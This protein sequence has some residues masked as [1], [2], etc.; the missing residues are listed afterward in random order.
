MLHPLHPGFANRKPPHL[1]KYIARSGIFGLI[2]GGIIFSGWPESSVWV[3]GLIPGIDLISNGV[4]WLSFGLRHSGLWHSGLR[5]A[6][7]EKAA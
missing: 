3:L 7:K 5:H 4:A 6:D 2:A 1:A